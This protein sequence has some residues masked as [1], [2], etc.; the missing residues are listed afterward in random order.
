MCFS[1]FSSG[2]RFAS[3]FPRDKSI[4]LR[5]ALIA[6][7]SEEADSRR[8]LRRLMDETIEYRI[9]RINTAKIR[10]QFFGS[11]RDADRFAIASYIQEMNVPRVPIVSP[12][13]TRMK[14]SMLSL[15]FDGTPSMPVRFQNHITIKEAGKHRPGSSDPHVRCPGRSGG[16]RGAVC[17][18]YWDTPLPYSGDES[19]MSPVRVSPHIRSAPREGKKPRRS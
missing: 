5:V 4:L 18:V 1:S 12:Y 7:N 14:L 17:G 3:N 11:D 13:I 2:E 8:F 16:F 10:P 6:D 9:T 15:L 19:G